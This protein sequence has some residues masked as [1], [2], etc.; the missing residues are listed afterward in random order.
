MKNK[1]ITVYEYIGLALLYST[2]YLPITI[3]LGVSLGL[4]V[5][6]LGSLKKRR[7]EVAGTS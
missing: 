4:S 2:I 3:I 5:I 1:L 7:Y 6:S